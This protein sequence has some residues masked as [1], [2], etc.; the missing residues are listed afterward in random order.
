MK[1]YLPFTII[2]LFCFL[3]CNT[4]TDLLISNIA[5]PLPQHEALYSKNEFKAL[6][7]KLKT[8]THQINK[9][10]TNIQAWKN[11]LDCHIMQSRVT[12][13]HSFAEKSNA[14]VEIL[15]QNKKMNIE[16]RF[17]LLSY[18][19]T[20]LLSLHEFQ[21][22][23]DAATSA[24]KIYPENAAILGA[25]IDANVE[26]GN[27]EA[28]VHLADKM[29]Q[30][31]PDL[32]SY[33]RVSYLRELHGDLNGAIAAMEDALSSCV[34]GQESCEW[35][36]VQL[37]KLYQKNKQND[38]AIMHFTM[39]IENRPNFTAA[40]SGLAE[41]YIDQDKYDEAW[42]IISQMEHR[43]SANK[44]ITSLKCK[45]FSKLN[46]V[47]NFNKEYTKLMNQYNLHASPSS[48]KNDKYLIKSKL[49]EKQM[50][51]E[52]KQVALEKAKDMINIKKDAKASLPYLLFEYKIRP[53][54]IEVNAYLS[55][56]YAIL[57]DDV[58]AKAHKALSIIQSTSLVKN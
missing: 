35:T 13:D 10:I 2:L 24:S 50:E 43:Q 48:S 7:K 38:F 54:N 33:S 56:A 27:Y 16:D 11:I 4:N 21:L 57:G 45:Y 53:A 20:A 14:I 25:K 47:T 42:K 34:P 5:S 36:R 40:N 49:K 39:A 8:A 22:A 31:R 26:L 28:A 9:K 58:K 17:A 46:D 30:M 51:H 52:M 41:L 32:R 23:L 29:V 44:E 37:A 15:L 55:K 12:G 6:N 3:S 18:K 1:L 19:A